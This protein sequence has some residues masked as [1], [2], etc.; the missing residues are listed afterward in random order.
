[1]IIF[2]NNVIV[3]ILKSKSLDICPVTYVPQVQDALASLFDKTPATFF[4]QVD[5]AKFIAANDNDYDTD[6]DD[7]AIC[8]FCPQI[9]T[10]FDFPPADIVEIGTTRGILHVANQPNSGER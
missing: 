9:F 5:M 8:C 3:V 4:S 10:L 6:A 2:I 1:V 7:V